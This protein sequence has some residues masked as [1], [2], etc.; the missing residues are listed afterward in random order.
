MSAV[1]IS[2]L[3]WG[4]GH[5]A[6]FLNPFSRSY[7]IW[8]PFIWFLQAFIIGIILSLIVL[9]RK[10]L[11]PIII[12]HALNNIISAQVVWS[13]FQGIS[14]TFVAMYLYYPL[15][16]IGICLFIW[17]FPMIKDSISTGS[18]MLGEYFKKDQ[19]S[20]KSK[21]DVAFRVFIDIMMGI[22]IFIM[23]F[24]IAV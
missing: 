3:Y 7:P 11:L 6:Y 12:A 24:I 17:F 15:L 10:W 13:F 16:I 22:L 18:K 2:T 14:F 9:R 21:G 4:F 19:M 5:F 8:Y 1:I 23:G 20:E